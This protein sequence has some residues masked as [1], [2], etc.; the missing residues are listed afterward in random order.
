MHFFIVLT[1]LFVCCSAKTSH[2]TLVILEYYSIAGLFSG[3]KFSWF[4][5]SVAVCWNIICEYCITYKVWVLW[6][7]NPWNM[8]LSAICEMFHPRNIPTIWYI[9][10]LINS[11]YMYRFGVLCVLLFVRWYSGPPLPQNA[12]RKVASY[13][14]L[15]YISHYTIELWRSCCFPTWRFYHYDCLV[16]P[17]TAI[18]SN[19]PWEKVSLLVEYE[20]IRSS[21]LFPTGEPPEDA[22]LKQ[23]VVLRTTKGIS[24]SALASSGEL[25]FD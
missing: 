8:L 16:A 12:W 14:Q 7:C 15:V 20:Q 2:V 13:W 9:I 18:A 11:L 5:G 17:A 23:Y 3:R 4:R 10:Q 22:R 25:L 6:N 1:C 21:P 19:F 24:A